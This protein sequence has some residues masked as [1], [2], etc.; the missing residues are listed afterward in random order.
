MKKLLFSVLTMAVVVFA[1]KKDE[2]E[3]KTVAEY[4]TGHQ[5]RTVSVTINP[6]YD[7][8][9]TGTKITDLF[10]PL[11]D[12]YKD[13]LLVFDDDGTFYLLNGSV[14]CEGDEAEREDQGEYTL[15]ADQK[16]LIREEY[17]VPAVIKEISD[18][19]L[20]LESTLI[21]NNVQ[22]SYT[23]TYKAE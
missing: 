10:A 9:R 4:L 15:S 21:E 12:C 14:K 22:Y 17:V 16:Q 6:A 1:C 13:D 3:T 8:Y 20:V 19:R 23:E 7:W 5:W 11:N 18:S 2:K